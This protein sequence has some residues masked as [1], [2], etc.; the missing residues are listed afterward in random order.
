MRITSVEDIS[1]INKPSTGGFVMVPD[2]GLSKWICSFDLNSLYPFIMA[3]LNLGHETL[4]IPNIYEPNGIRKF[5]DEELNGDVQ[6]FID[7]HCTHAV[8]NVYFWKDH[9]S[10]LTKIL[11]GHY[12]LRSSIRQDVK[13]DKKLKRKVKDELRKRGIEV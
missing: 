11:V 6:R 2:L 13:K 7:N 10:I 4:F 5:I 3:L 1:K 9:D 12:K 8:N